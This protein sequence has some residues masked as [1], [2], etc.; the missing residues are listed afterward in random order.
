MKGERLAVGWR[1]GPVA[2]V[3]GCAA[4]LLA[5]A[6]AIHAFGIAAGF[7]MLA[8][9]GLAAL[10]RWQQARLQGPSLMLRSLRSLGRAIPVHAIAVGRL[11]Y[12]RARGAARLAVR[13]DDEGLVLRAVGPKPGLDAFRHLAMWMIV[14]GRRQAYVDPAL[15]DALAGMADHARARADASHV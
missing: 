15:L 11:E 6:L 1:P 12:R 10:S 5:A 13:R 7:A 8:I 9:A 4:A 14:H 2:S 3:V